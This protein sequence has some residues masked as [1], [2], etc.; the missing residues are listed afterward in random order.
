MVLI[1]THAHLYFKEFGEDREAVIEKSQEQSISQVYLPNIDVSTIEAMLT[2]EA[3]YPTYCKAMMG[4]HPCYI[5]AHF[6][7]QLKQVAYWL[8]KRRFVAIGEIGIDLYHDKTFRAQQTE[9]LT[10]QLAWARQYQLPVVIHC[11]ASL[12]ETLTILEKYQDGK[13]KGIFHC[14][15]GSLQD[16]ERIIE[17]G[18]YLGVGGLVT[19]KNAGLA[20]VV[21]ALDLDHLVLETDSPYLAPIPHRGMR[22]EPAYLLHIAEKIA[23]LHKTDLA[24]VAQKTTSNA[25]KVFEN[26]N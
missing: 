13:L 24:T 10:L 21:A 26:T 18:F 14:F 12:E 8:E 9:A 6:E 22:N 17:L 1:D 19:F 20:S 25:K 4:I 7:K 2:L 3:Q 5:D 15:S 23:T 16:A 11:R